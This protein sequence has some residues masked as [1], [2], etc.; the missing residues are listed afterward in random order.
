MTEAGGLPR[1]DDAGA[2]VVLQ[3]PHDLVTTRN[4]REMRARLDVMLGD[5]N[6]VRSRNVQ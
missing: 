6:A 3:A 2:V 1:D 5:E 4:S